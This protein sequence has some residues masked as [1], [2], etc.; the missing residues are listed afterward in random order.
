MNAE[1]RKEL[2][3]WEERSRGQGR[4]SGASREPKL[5]MSVIM[6]SGASCSSGKA[7]GLEGISAELLKS[8]PLESF[9][10]NQKGV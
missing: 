1:A 6:Q 3:E 7:V 10:E 9:A 8:I 5:T 4:E 2:E